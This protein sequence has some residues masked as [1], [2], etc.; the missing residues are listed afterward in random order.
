[1][2][3]SP[4]GV[5][6]NATRDDWRLNMT[7]PVTP[8]RLA[9]LRKLKQFGYR[10]DAVSPQLLPFDPQDEWVQVKGQSFL[11]LRQSVEWNDPVGPW[12][13]VSLHDRAGQLS[14][15]QHAWWFALASVVLGALG[16]LVLQVELGRRRVN[17]ARTRSAMLGAALEVSPISIVITNAAGHIE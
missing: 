13:L 8:Q 11:V 14:P 7:P 2:L 12:T 4:Q 17:A 9:D 3:L 6:F 10:F 5:V 16:L 1:M 15:S